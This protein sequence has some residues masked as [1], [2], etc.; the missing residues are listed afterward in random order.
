M[1]VTA[2]HQ[3]ARYIT[4]YHFLSC[5][6]VYLVVE[7]DAGSEIKTKQLLQNIRSHLAQQVDEVLQQKECET[8]LTLCD[9][10]KSKEEEPE[11]DE[12]D[13]PPPPKVRGH[14][15]P[16]IKVT[17]KDV[18]QTMIHKGESTNGTLA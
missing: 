6:V 8:G 17:P 3:L 13:I 1:K 12:D 5:F 14:H 16:L 9:P 7:V 10:S 2:L 15:K 18:I 11:E 4:T